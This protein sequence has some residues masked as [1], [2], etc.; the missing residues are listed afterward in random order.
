MTLNGCEVVDIELDGVN[1]RDY[2][3]FVDA[4]VSFARWESNLEPLTEG[5]CADLTVVM[6]ESG[7]MFERI[8]SR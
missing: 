5:E 2:P 8:I 3:D 4:F 6:Q 1:R 7:A